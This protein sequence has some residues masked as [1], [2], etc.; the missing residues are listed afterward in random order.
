MKY[1]RGKI[2]EYVH[3]AKYDLI[4]R[5]DESRELMVNSV[6]QNEGIIKYGLLGLY[7]AINMVY[8]VLGIMLDIVV[9]GIAVWG[10]FVAFM[11]WLC[12]LIFH[13]VVTLLISMAFL[14]PFSFGCM[15]CAKLSEESATKHK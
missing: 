2:G 6:S 15:Y 7:T 1:F 12:L 4:H 10:A 13:P 11:T 3:D 9:F 5:W 8:G 14:L